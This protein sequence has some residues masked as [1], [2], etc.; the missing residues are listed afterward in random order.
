VLYLA[1]QGIKYELGYHQDVSVQI[2]QT[3]MTEPTRT[4][5]YFMV[6][7]LIVLFIIR[8]NKK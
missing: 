1:F 4:T 2:W 7:L 3:F 8:G 6:G 5:V